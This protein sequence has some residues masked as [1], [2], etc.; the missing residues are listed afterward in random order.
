MS[1]LYRINWSDFWKGLLL[2]LIVAI[3]SFISKFFNIPILETD[4]VG[5]TAIVA[6]IGYIIKNFITTK[7][8]RLLGF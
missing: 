4:A 2:A 8:G 7:E 3:I 6:F 1:D 5:N